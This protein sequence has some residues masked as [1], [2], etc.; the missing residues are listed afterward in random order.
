M[1]GLGRGGD[2]KDGVEEGW[3]GEMGRGGGV[4]LLCTP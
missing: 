2:G 4:G 3:G 1:G